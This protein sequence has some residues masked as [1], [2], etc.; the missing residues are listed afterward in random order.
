MNTESLAES[1]LTNELKERQNILLK[2]LRE[3]MQ[4]IHHIQ[5]TILPELY[6]EYDKHFRALEIEVQRTTLIASELGRREELFRTKLLRGEV[7]SAQMIELVNT[8]VDKEFARMRKRFRESFEMDKTEREQAAT[9]RN[10]AYNES[11]F[12]QLYRE[13]VKKLHPDTNLPSTH[14]TTETAFEQE[15]NL[16]ER[17]WHSAQDAYQRKSTR[18]LQVIY[19]LVVAGSNTSTTSIKIE[20]IPELQREVTR[21]EGRLRVEER[22]LRDLTTGE[23]YSLQELMKSPTWCAAEQEKLRKEIG[24]QQRNAERSRIF[25]ASIHAD[26]GIEWKD[27]PQSRSQQENEAFHNDFMESTYFSGR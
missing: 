25:L 10:E 16:F 5:E 12:A 2:R 1:P 8:I 19:D 18:D 6:R 15:S 9:R 21:L 27:I 22:K 14:S 23:P 4:E 7:L 17:F 13:I 3:V 20:T 24:E 26:L 11:E